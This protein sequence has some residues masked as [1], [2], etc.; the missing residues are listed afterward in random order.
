MHK[1]SRLVTL[2]RRR[3]QSL[4]GSTDRLCNKVGLETALKGISDSVVG[5]SLMT[6]GKS[7]QTVRAR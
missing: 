7:F 4:G 6:R 5:E 1:V 2:T 3:R